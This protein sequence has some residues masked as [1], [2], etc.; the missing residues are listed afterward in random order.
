MLPACLI[1]SGLLHQALDVISQAAPSDLPVKTGR[2][3]ARSA[4]PATAVAELLAVHVLGGALSLHAARM[5]F[6]VLTSADKAECAS[7]VS[8]TC[9]AACIIV[10]HYAA[11]QIHMLH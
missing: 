5:L 11:D 3:P 10:T 2:P 1:A 8:M 6:P 9:G 7:Q 4:N